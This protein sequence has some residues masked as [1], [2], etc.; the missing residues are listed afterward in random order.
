M[1]PFCVQHGPIGKHNW[2]IN[3]QTEN[4]TV[5]LLVFTFLKECFV[6]VV[7]QQKMHLTLSDLIKLK[8]SRIYGHKY[9][10]NI[11]IQTQHRAAKDRSGRNSPKDHIFKKL[12]SWAIGCVCLFV[13]LF[14][15]SANSGEENLV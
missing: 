12:G 6:F 3:K 8:P 2:S 11:K 14:R 5:K 13:C 9:N 15:S 4:E 7:R 10:K 1:Y